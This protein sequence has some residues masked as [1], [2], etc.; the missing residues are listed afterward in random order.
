MAHTHKTIFFLNYFAQ[1][2]L[3]CREPRYKLNILSKFPNLFTISF[4]NFGI[5]FSIHTFAKL[6][7]ESATVLHNTVEQILHSVATRLEQITKFLF[8]N[9][10]NSSCYFIPFREIKFLVNAKEIFL[11]IKYIK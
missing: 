7:G 8:A 6:R 4:L 1:T 11:K 10:S 5:K 3:C 9:N 2:E